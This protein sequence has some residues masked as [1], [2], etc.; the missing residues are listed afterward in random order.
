MP[1]T[2]NIIHTMK[3][4]VK[5]SVLT[6]STDKAC[7]LRCGLSPT[8]SDA[9]AMG[10]SLFPVWQASSREDRVLPIPLQDGS[11]RQKG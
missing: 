10:F 11:A 3:Q 1:I 5:A 2:P 4:T 8:E 6:K 7:R 9:F